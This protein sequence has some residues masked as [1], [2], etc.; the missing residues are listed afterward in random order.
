MK[1][2]CE[3]LRT[4]A[5][6]TIGFEKKKMLQLT[7]KELKSHEDAEKYYICRIK[8]FRK[9]RDKN[10]YKVTDR[11]HYTGIYRGAGHSICN[12]KF[13]VP[14]ETPVVFHITVQIMIIT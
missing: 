2:F 5:K 7:I 1:K 6:S 10:Y 12:L 9:L 3:C 13:N 14:N 11:C 4:S 8:L